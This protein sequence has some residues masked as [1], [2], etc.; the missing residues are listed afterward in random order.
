[1]AAELEHLFE[2]IAEEDV[3]ELTEVMTRAFD[4]DAQVHLGEDKG[5]PPGYD[6][7]SFFREWLFAYEQSVGYKVVSEDKI[8][9]ATIVWILPGADN[10][11]G[12]IFVDPAYQNRGIGTR[13][14]R[15]IED[16]YPDTKSWKLYTPPW[17][18][19]N[20]YFYEQKCGFRMVG[21]EEEGIL[22][23]KEMAGR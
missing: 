8:V 14:W 18:T 2:E 12:T 1:M 10:I 5:G 7:G 20:H 17:A 19:K 9:G 23:L 13:T 21:E 4:D 15:F 3:P 22:F 6:D 16:T 11:L